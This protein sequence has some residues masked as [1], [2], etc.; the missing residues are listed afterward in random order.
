MLS[1]DGPGSVDT[2]L[3]A[4][5]QCTQFLQALSNKD[6]ADLNQRAF[7]S[8]RE[9]PADIRQGLCNMGSAL[10][11]SAA[12]DLTMF[13]D[14]CIQAV[15]AGR[16]EA[17]PP[18]PEAT[19]AG[20][21]E[22]DFQADYQCSSGSATPSPGRMENGKDDSFSEEDVPVTGT[23]HTP[24]PGDAHKDDSVPPV[25]S[26]PPSCSHGPCHTSS[27]QPVKRKRTRVDRDKV[28]NYIL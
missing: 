14:A 22:A 12:S 7:P 3:R 24:N 25:D 21:T 10:R 11:A 2:T 4:I 8:N 18:T 23:T 19:T 26:N 17:Q 13:Q 6:Y 28:L 15:N 1:P 20:T 9:G 5:D 16:V 27:R